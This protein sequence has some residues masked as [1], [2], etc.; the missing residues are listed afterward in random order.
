MKKKKGNNHSH[1][2]PTATFMLLFNQRKRY[3]SEKIMKG[4]PKIHFQKYRKKTKLLGKK[5]CTQGC[6]LNV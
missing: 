1:L 6:M 4:V 3:V 2:T 5:L